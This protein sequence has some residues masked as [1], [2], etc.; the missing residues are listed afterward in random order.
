MY[1]NSL[2]Q[3]MSVKYYGALHLCLFTRLC[4]YKYDATPLL[5]IWRGDAAEEK[6]S[7]LKG[8]LLHNL[9]L[10]QQIAGSG[11]LINEE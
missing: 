6:I 7:P 4:R 10:F 9:H 1:L 5:H 8:M 2:K 3:R 11:I